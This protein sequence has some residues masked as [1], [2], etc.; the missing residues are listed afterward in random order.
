MP[1]VFGT[2]LHKKQLLNS[3]HAVIGQVA[4]SGAVGGFF[5]RQTLFAD[6]YK[7][8]SEDD[9]SVSCKVKAGDVGILALQ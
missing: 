4:N 8:E 7:G 2:V 6:A 5:Q 1:V 3:L 9:V